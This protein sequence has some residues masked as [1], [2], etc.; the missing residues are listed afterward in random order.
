MKNSIGVLFKKLLFIVAFVSLLN[1]YNL[2]AQTSIGVLG[3]VNF[4]KFQL[5]DKEWSWEVPEYSRSKGWKAG[6][7]IEFGSNNLLSLQL[8]PMWVQKKSV[9]TLQNMHEPPTL[10]FP[11]FSQTLNYFELPAFVKLSLGKGNIRPYLLGGGE[12]AFLISATEKDLTWNNETY[13][14]KDRFEQFDYGYT[15]GGGIEFP[16]FN[17][18][19]FFVE[20]RKSVGLANINKGSFENASVSTSGLQVMGGVKIPLFVQAEPCDCENLTVLGYNFHVNKPVTNAGNVEITITLIINYKLKCE[21]GAVRNECSGTLEWSRVGANAIPVIPPD[22]WNGIVPVELINDDSKTVTEKCTKKNPQKK[23]W[24]SNYKINIPGT[25]LPVTGTVEFEFEASCL[26]GTTGVPR[27]I[28]LV[29]DTGKPGRINQLASDL[30]GD[31][32]T[33][34]EEKNKKTDPNNWDTDGDKIND[35]DDPN[36]LKKD[37]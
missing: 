8:E 1:T 27:T 26:G 3:G 33:G 2:N 17:K 23:V 5:E 12:F 20:A 30:D 10:P 21:K 34:A 31:G 37:N 11:Q 13:D 19:S 24:I 25:A 7:L 35:K 28:K 22:P 15:Y 6:G 32:L 4:S 9:L 18:A 16:I 14:I 36:P 29:V